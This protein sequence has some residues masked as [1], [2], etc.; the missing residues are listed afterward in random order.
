VLAVFEG[1]VDHL[2]RYA[3]GAADQLDDDVD[4]GIGGHRRRILVP[5]HRR[6]VDAAIAAAVAS[7]D[8][9]D[10]H[11]ATGALR[12]EIGLPVEQLQGA[13]AD[14]AETR[15]GNLQRRF[16]DNDGSLRREQFRQ[17]LGSLAPKA[18]ILFA[19]PTRCRDRGKSGSVLEQHLGAVFGGI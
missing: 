4:L 18:E 14:R 13:G 15:D 12:Q 7:G 6:E 5:A 11:P 17:N 9:N 2:L 16:H 19:L 8:R 10:D 3:V 1:G